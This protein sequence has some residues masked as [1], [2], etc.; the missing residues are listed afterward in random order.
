MNRADELVKAAVQVAH[1]IRSPLAALSVIE[2]DLSALPDETRALL[3]AAIS[4]IREIASDLL[5]RS[6]GGSHGAPGVHPIAPLIEALAA[7][8]R[9]Q[10]RLLNEVEIGAE[11]A[12]PDLCGVI[13]PADFLRM[14]SNAIDNAVEA[15]R[16]HGRVVVNVSGSQGAVQVHV[17]DNGVGMTAEV[18]RGAGREGFSHGKPRGNGLGLSH[19]KRTL[20][21]WGGKLRIVSAWGGGTTV[22]FTLGRS[23]SSFPSGN[24][25]GA[26]SEQSYE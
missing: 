17:M 4:R 10:Y 18:L 12:Q 22:T 11:Y 5:D 19:A 9:L 24:D 15:C 21:A 16:G 20:E 6:R 23:R 2:Q 26:R 14:V 25:P 13:V 3:K 7:E 8:K 1:D